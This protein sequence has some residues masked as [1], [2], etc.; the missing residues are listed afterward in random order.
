MRTV[1][2]FMLDRY[3]A[4]ATDSGLPVDFDSHHPNE[5]DLL[6]MEQFQRLPSTQDKK[7]IIRQSIAPALRIMAEDSKLSNFVIDP[8]RLFSNCT[9]TEEYLRLTR[10]L[11]I[12]PMLNP[13]GQFI[14]E[15]LSAQY[16]R[17]L[18]VH[19]QN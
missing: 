11:G 17:N 15:Y 2:P 14:A 3:V 5:I 13:V 7:Q 18:Y 8:S 6:A 19:N 4:A 9:F 12:S 10:F 16:H 1:N